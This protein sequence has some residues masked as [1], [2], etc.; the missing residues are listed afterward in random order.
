[1]NQS[2]ALKFFK[3]TKLKFVEYYKYQFTYTGEK[4]DKLIIVK[5]GGDPDTISKLHFTARLIFD[6]DEEFE[7]MKV[8]EVN[9]KD[10]YIFSDY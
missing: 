9:N 10:T 8:K 1:M 3:G 7:Y 4:D 2:E 6:I 5:F